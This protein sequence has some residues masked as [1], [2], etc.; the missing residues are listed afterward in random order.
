MDADFC[1]NCESL[2]LRLIENTSRGSKKMLPFRTVF[3]QL[4]CKGKPLAME[5]V[6]KP[7]IVD[8]D[9]ALLCLPNSTCSNIIDRKFLSMQMNDDYDEAVK[10]AFNHIEMLGQNEIPDECD[11]MIEQELN[12][13]NL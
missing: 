4:L 6:G 10:R 7:E 12:E 3:V 9:Y 8:E 13:L 1:K 11:F 2:K 5:P